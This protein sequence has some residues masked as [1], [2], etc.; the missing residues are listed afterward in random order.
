[1]KQL[2][3]ILPSIPEEVIPTTDHI[4]VMREPLKI[5]H[6]VSFLDDSTME[7]LYTKTIKDTLQTGNTIR[8]VVVAVSEEATEKY[9]LMEGDIV[10]F[11]AYARPTVTIDR[12]PLLIMRGSD[13]LTTLPHLT[14]GEIVI[15]NE[16][17]RRY[18]DKMVWGDLLDAP[19]PL[20]GIIS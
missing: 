17:Q 4:L 8:G 14:E 20:R 3:L 18:V 9:G 11:P 1:M 6:T 16:N 7:S 15:W 13:T 5:P 10:A 19:K 12:T 2:S